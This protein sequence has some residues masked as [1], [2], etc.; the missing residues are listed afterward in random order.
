[1]WNPR[2]SLK[3]ENAP[4]GNKDLSNG[5][6]LM[7]ALVKPHRQKLNPYGRSLPIRI[8]LYV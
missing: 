5:N 6:Q 7:Q 8:Q 2:N 4:A 1:M 3:K